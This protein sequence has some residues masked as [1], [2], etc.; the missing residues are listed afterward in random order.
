[1]AH[2]GWNPQWIGVYQRLIG[3]YQA[4]A[5]F[6]PDDRRSERQTVVAGHK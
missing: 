1:M 3:L 4:C 5:A 6:A 2:A